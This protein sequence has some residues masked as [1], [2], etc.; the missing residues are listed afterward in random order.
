MKH[1][2]NICASFII[3]ALCMPT[4]VLGTQNRDELTNFPSMSAELAAVDNLNQELLQQ[5]SEEELHW[6]N[7]FQHGLMFFD[8]W[9]DISKDI[10]ANLSYEEKNRVKPLLDSMGLRI[11]TEWSKANDVR[12]IDTDQLRNWG[13]RL[14]NAQH[15]GSE[16]LKETVFLISTEVEA[17]LLRKQ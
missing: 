15:Q 1:L 6:Y 8:G 3:L 12:K 5:L 16:Y 4:Y 13:K 7:K 10:L 11:G 17:I 14:K 9:K 2:M